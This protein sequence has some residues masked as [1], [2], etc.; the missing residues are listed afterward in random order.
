MS[1]HAAIVATVLPMAA[2]FRAVGS[3]P[4][5]TAFHCGL[6]QLYFKLLW[7]RSKVLMGRSSLWCNFNRYIRR[8]RIRAFPYRRMVLWLRDCNSR[9]RRPV[10]YRKSVVVVVIAASDHRWISCTVRFHNRWCNLY[11]Y[12]R[13]LRRGTFRFRKKRLRL[14]NRNS[15]QGR[16]IRDRKTV[17][18]VAASGSRL[19]THHKPAF[20][21]APDSRWMKCTA[22]VHNRWRGSWLGSS[23]MRLPPGFGVS[24]R[25]TM[26]AAIERISRWIV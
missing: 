3:V 26:A 1:L 17:I 4:T 9:R 19:G 14:R 15:R 8:L 11:C 13:R 2:L 6:N 18:V 25:V 16:S 23:P 7:L 21:A 24:I 5:N 10:R 12:I 22:R 20:W